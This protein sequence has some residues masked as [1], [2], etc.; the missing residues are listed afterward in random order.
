MFYV[1]RDSNLKKGNESFMKWLKLLR[2]EIKCCFLSPNI[3]TYYDN[4]YFVG[5]KLINIKGGEV[6]CIRYVNDI[7]EILQ[8]IKEN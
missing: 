4:R 1:V 2:R 5:E 8:T 3:F 6:N 7:T